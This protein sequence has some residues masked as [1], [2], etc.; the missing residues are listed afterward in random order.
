MK[1]KVTQTFL[2]GSD[3]FEK[4]DE[5][6]VP[7]KLGAYFVA[8]GW[9]TDVAGRVATGVSAEQQATLNIDNSNLSS[10]DSNG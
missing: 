9:A 4:D 3:R 1:I 10:G 2:E 8:K 5:R 6:T 7:D